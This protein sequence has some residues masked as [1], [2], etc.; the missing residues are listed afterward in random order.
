MYAVRAKTA[1]G[2]HWNLYEIGFQN[3]QG[4]SLHGVLSEETG[5]QKRGF[6]GLG[7]ALPGVRKLCFI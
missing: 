5:V 2:R 4:I 7:K 3:R 6:R 1:G